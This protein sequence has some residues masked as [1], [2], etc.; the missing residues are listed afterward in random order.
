MGWGAAH[1]VRR[2]LASVSP[3]NKA[4]LATIA[5][6]G[7]VRIG[8]QIDEIDGL[9]WIHALELSQGETIQQENH[10]LPNHR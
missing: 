7:F 9:E 8:E 1:G 4:S 10:H 2:C 6:P 5:R 3:H